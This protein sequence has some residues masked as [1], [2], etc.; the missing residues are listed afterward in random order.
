MPLHIIEKNICE[1]PLELAERFKKEKTDYEIKKYSYCGKL[2]PMAR[3][4]MLLLTNET[5]KQQD[6][7]IKIDKTYQF[8]M[9]FGIETDTYDVLGIIQNPNNILYKHTEEDI[10]SQIQYHTLNKFNNIDQLFVGKKEQEFPPYSS[11]CVKNKD[12]LRN[13]LWWWSKN[14]RYDEIIPPHKEVE[15]Y[16][17]K[18]LSHNTI[19]FHTL[20][21]SIKNNIKKI[22]GD[23]R[24]SETLLYWEQLYNDNNDKSLLSI[25]FE[26]KVSSGTY[27]RSLI[28]DIAKYYNTKAIAIDINRTHLHFDY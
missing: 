10:Q 2:D 22:K 28:Q 14:N 26:A 5:C 12:G 3:G 4:K 1:T 20:Y 25:K 15:I 6:E 21:T 27:I 7:L 24:Q 23:F 16:S 9:V 11:I 18:F 13:P 8:T 17:L 19:S